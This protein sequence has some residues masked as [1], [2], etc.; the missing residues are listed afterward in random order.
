MSRVP[1]KVEAN[2]RGRKVR[3]FIGDFGGFRFPGWLRFAGYLIVS[4]HLCARSGS[5]GIAIALNVPAVRYRAARAWFGFLIAARA[6]E[7]SGAAPV[8]SR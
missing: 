5:R 4:C 8:K 7:S 3:P 2:P 6:M 1:R